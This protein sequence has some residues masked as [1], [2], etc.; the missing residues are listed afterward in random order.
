MFT[1][2]I[3]AMD[4]IRM[5]MTPAIGIIKVNTEVGTVEVEAEKTKLV[6]PVL[7]ISGLVLVLGLW[8]GVGMH[9]RMRS[10]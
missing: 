7:E 6:F 9:I 10:V 1:S 3:V 4:L 8:V 2:E 5:D